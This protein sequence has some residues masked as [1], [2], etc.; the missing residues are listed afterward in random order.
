MPFENRNTYIVLEARVAQ[1]L[2][3]LHL[4]AVVPGSIP[5]RGTSCELSLLARSLL[6]LRVFSPGP[7]V[8][9]PPSKMNW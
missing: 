9:L 6:V 7:L 2:D 3:R 8:F 5:E 1:W 4:T